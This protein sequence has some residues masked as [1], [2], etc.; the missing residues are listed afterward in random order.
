MI[1][2]IDI[3]RLHKVLNGELNSR[4]SGRTFAMLVIAV[5]CAMIDVGY[6]RNFGI[7][8]DCQAFANFYRNQIL[9]IASLIDRDNDSRV[10]LSNK[11]ITINSGE[12]FKTKLYSMTHREA[13]RG[14]YN[15]IGFDSIFVDHEVYD[16]HHE[17]GLMVFEQLIKQ[18]KFKG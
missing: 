4:G 1:H 7:V 17:N 5:Q 2:N 14:N 18:N 16:Q 11:H 13:Q 9:D 15:G 3:D 6:D 8:F 12:S 10:T